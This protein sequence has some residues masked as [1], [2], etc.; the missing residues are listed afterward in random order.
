[1]QAQ[2]KP[3]TLKTISNLSMKRVTAGTWSGDTDDLS[4]TR[5]TAVPAGQSGRTR[6]TDAQITNDE[7]QPNLFNN[8]QSSKVIAKEIVQ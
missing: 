5:K 8:G 3:P 6:G 2:Q 1:M 7:Q 4:I